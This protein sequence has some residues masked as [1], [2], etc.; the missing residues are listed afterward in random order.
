VRLPGEDVDGRR[1]SNLNCSVNDFLATLVCGLDID[2][3]IA[4][5]HASMGEFD[6][7]L[8]G[9]SIPTSVMLYLPIGK[10]YISCH[11]LQGLKRTL[12]L[13][14]CCHGIWLTHLENPAHSEEAQQVYLLGPEAGQWLMHVQSA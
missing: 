5:T 2:H 13:L 3:Y 6:S 1:L 4:I 7:Q 12:C 14:L 8:Q 11:H 9:R 10:C